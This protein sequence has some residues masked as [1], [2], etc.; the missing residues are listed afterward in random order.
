V[1]YQERISYERV[2]LGFRVWLYDSASV[3]ANS[4][5]LELF[6]ITKQDVEP[7]SKVADG[8]AVI[9]VGSALDLANLGSYGQTV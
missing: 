2:L 8:I 1:L 5:F 4:H 7:D 6:D 9:L 3:T